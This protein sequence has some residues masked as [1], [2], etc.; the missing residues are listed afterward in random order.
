[1]LEYVLSAQSPD[2][3]RV[4]LAVEADSADEAVADLQAQ[5]Y[6][7]IVLHTS[8]LHVALMEQR[9]GNAALAPADYLR[10]RRSRGYLA[11]VLFWSQYSYRRYWQ[12]FGGAAVYVALRRST[13]LPLGRDEL[14]C[15]AVL[16][17]P[18]VWQALLQASSAGRSYQRLLEAVS[19]HRWNDVLEYIAVIG[20]R[21]SPAEAAFREAQALAGLG[22]LAAALARVRP[23]AEDRDLPPWYYSARLAE[24]YRVAG[25]PE[26][27]LAAAEQ[28][29]QLAPDEP[30]ILIDLAIAL[31]RYRRD[32]QRARNLLQRA[33]AHAM[34]DV[35]APFLSLAEGML[36]LADERPRHAFQHLQ[37][38]RNGFAALRR[39]NP[40]V[41]ATLDRT[42]AYLALAYTALG[43]P[44]AAIR[45]FRRAAPRLEATNDLDLLRRCR[46]AIGTS[47]ASA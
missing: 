38:A 43:D 15:L 29:F 34:S 37:S 28:A 14:L 33:R 31:L 47:I 5:G 24:V 8:N 1:M 2:G 23:L 21:L 26:A 44:D 25:R 41:R 46:N 7:D 3:A 35:E 11:N 36:A 22:N 18:I 32:T 45:A 42:D 4:A 17:F 27:V 16:A 40:L 9:N 20:H 13:G 6:T 30:A 39:M 19:W 10:F 12:I